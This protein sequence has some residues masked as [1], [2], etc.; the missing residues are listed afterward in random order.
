MIIYCT[1]A[2]LK[3]LYYKILFS[4]K[5]KENPTR[6]N[7]KCN[8]IMYLMERW[9][10]MNRCYCYQRLKFITETYLI[11]ATF[12]LMDKVSQNT[13]PVGSI[14]HRECAQRQQEKPVRL[15]ISWKMNSIHAHGW[16][17]MEFLFQLADHKPYRGFTV[18][19]RTV[20]IVWNKPTFIKLVIAK[21]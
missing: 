10:T 18:Q 7:K 17:A 2:V 12:N 21:P 3:R 9:K 5:N 8:I 14:V 15:M 11:S 1:F 16:L 20:P 4:I 6:M 13:T 19:L